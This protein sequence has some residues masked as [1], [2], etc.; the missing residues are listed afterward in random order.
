M[1]IVETLCERLVWAF[2]NENKRSLKTGTIMVNVGC[3]MPPSYVL[4]LPPPST[5]EERLEFISYI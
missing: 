1:S 3:L 5:S 4:P 2:P